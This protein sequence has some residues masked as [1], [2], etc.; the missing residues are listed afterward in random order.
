MR[1]L[2]P[3]EAKLLADASAQHCTDG[4]RV[5]LTSEEA[6]LYHALAEIGRAKSAPCPCHGIPV[7]TITKEGLEALALWRELRELEKEPL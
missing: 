7:I 6:R 4:A 1:G 3:A 2:T 5:P